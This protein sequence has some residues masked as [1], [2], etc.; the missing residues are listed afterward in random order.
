MRI[1]I[2]FHID[3]NNNKKEKIKKI[4]VFQNNGKLYVKSIV[5][6]YPQREKKNV[7]NK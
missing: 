1:Q 7:M 2:Y 3:E 4:E 6:F 5:F